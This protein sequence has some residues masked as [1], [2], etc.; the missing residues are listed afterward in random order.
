[1]PLAALGKETPVR[2][3]CSTRTIASLASAALV[4]FGC[5]TDDRADDPQASSADDAADDVTATDDIDEFDA[6]AAYDEF[7]EAVDAFYGGDD[8]ALEELAAD[9]VLEVFAVQTDELVVLG[10][11]E[12]EVID[13]DE[14][15]GTVTIT[16]CVSD[17]RFTASEEDAAQLEDDAFRTGREVWATHTTVLE[18]AGDGGWQVVEHDD[19]LTDAV[20]GQRDIYSGIPPEG[21]SDCERP[22]YAEA[23]IELINDY[24]AA[25]FDMDAE[26]EVEHARPFVT[27]EVYDNLAA[28]T[29]DRIEQ[30]DDVRTEVDARWD[31]EVVQLDSE[32][33]IVRRCDYYDTW[34][35]RQ[36]DEVVDD[37]SGTT[38]G[39]DL[40]VTFHAYDTPRVSASEQLDGG[41]CDDVD[42]HPFSHSTN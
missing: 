12:H 33:A 8:G 13:V 23:A 34:I 37:S 25:V 3:S 19:P 1:M 38:F 2:R 32:G 18:T 17:R 35:A 27:D 16:D 9:A 20:T 29:Q 41:E 5:G 31:V 15:N 40:W 7:L 28:N 11:R 10:T 14:G 39:R 24:T 21:Y 30:H 22:S 6:E 26:N 4:L 36:G 42:D